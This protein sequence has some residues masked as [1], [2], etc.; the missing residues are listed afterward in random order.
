MRHIQSEREPTIALIN[1]VFLMLVFF[2]IAGTLAPPMDREVKLINTADLEGSAPPDTLVIHADGAL[3][4]RGEAVLDAE[5]YVAG[6]SEEQRAA[7]RVVPDRALPAK[8]LVKI[9]NALRAA[10][11][12]RVILVSERALK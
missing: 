9:G 11:A 2:M 12:E 4:Y 6:L 3:A 8:E 5:A 1:I 10:G 7:L